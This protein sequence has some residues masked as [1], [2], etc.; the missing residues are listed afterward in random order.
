MNG[1]SL[2]SPTLGRDRYCG[3]VLPA[4][5]ESSGNMITIN[6]MTD[7]SVSASGFRLRY[8]EVEVA[9]GGRLRLTEEVTEGYLTSPNFPAEYPD[10]VDCVWVIVAP[11]S[12][13]IQV[14][15]E[16]Q[17]I[18]ESHSRFLNLSFLAR[19]LSSI[20]FNPTNIKKFVFF[21]TDI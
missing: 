19:T 9:C 3:S 14:H 21:M 10:N 16:E 1:M 5:P 12:R 15:F 2:D 20:F 18:L 6:F 13:R 8:R 4:I 7:D 11:S 17:F